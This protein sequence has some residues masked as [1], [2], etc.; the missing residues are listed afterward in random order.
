[1][2]TPKLFQPT[3]IGDVQLTH[4]VV[5]APMTRF[6]ADANHVPL[7]H[8]AEY[9][10]QRASTP[11]TL[12]ISEGTVIAPQAGGFENVPGIWS[13]EQIAAWKEVASRVHAQGSFMFL[14]IA[15][16]GRTALPAV[17]EKEGGFPYVGASD[18]RHA[19]RQQAPRA[20]TKPE[21]AEY[22]RLFAVAASNAV[23]EAGFD[24]VELHAG[25][26]YLLD[27][28][29]HDEVNTRD[30]EYGGEPV[31]NRAR[32]VLEVVKAVVDAVG[33]KKTAVRISPWNTSQDMHFDDPRPTYTYLVT[34]LRNRFP[35]LAYL[36]VIEPR[37]NGHNDVSP[38][39]ESASNDFIRAI[40]SGRPLISAGGY[41]RDTAIATAE[42]KGDLIAFGRMFLANPDLPYRLKNDIPLTVGR[43]EL[44]YAP[45][46]TNPEGFTD[47]RFA[48]KA[49]V[50]G[51][52]A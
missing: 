36:H 40:W 34:E 12:L 1:M 24:G 16:L 27:Q 28:F 2:T 26:G 39:D 21:L 17:L 41:K 10:A 44:Y 45:G 3:R 11:G 6:R 32:F 7:P 22:A 19:E 25:N 5:L 37:V 42:V 31:E 29:L 46:S 20:L 49:N 15:A 4:R 33:E 18:V 23:H 47:Y 43:R 13:A 35:E 52:P 51:S 9:Y 14:Q 50:S 8:V 48:D 38:K 30:N